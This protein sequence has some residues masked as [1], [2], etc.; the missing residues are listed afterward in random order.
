MPVYPEL[1]Q[2]QGMAENLL[3]GAHPEMK[4]SNDGHELKFPI[5]K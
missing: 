2:A 4:I 5:Q 1:W 3:A